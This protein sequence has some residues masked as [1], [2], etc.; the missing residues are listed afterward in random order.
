[1]APNR[2]A[3]T[4]LLPVDDEGAGML[5]ADLWINIC[6]SLLVLVTDPSTRGLLSNMDV[7]S[8]G[9]ASHPVQVTQIFVGADVDHSLHFGAADG[10][11]IAGQDDL[12]AIIA[13]AQARDLHAVLQLIVP[14]DLPAVTLLETTTRLE[15]AGA[16]SI[17]LAAK[18]Q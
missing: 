3:P 14:Q 13:D 8:Q 10:R 1:M 4:F 15:Q 12:S 5:W 16:K 17:T 2:I 9:Q 7:N 11:V 6:F 18:G